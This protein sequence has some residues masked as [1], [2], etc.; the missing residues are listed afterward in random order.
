MAA[1]ATEL[2]T[3]RCGA[4]DDQRAQLAQARQTRGGLDTETGA[5]LAGDPLYHSSA[6]HRGGSPNTTHS[7]GA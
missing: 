3:P 1:H 5:G 4:L 2:E 7:G 6:E